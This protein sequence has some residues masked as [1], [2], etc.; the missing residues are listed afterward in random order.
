MENK[1]IF[2]EYFKK[3]NIQIKNIPFNLSPISKSTHEQ[4]K[5][6]SSVDFKDFTFPTDYIQFCIEIGAGKLGRCRI[7]APTSNMGPTDLRFH[8]FRLLSKFQEQKTKV[9]Q[10]PLHELIIFANDIE[11]DLWFGWRR[12]NQN[13]IYVIDKRKDAPP[14]KKIADNFIEFLETVCLGNRMEKMKIK[15]YFEP[16]KEPK[17]GEEN[18]ISDDDDSDDENSEKSNEPNDVENFPPKTFTPFPKQ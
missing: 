4:F 11:E 9:H 17:E 2:S 8:T 5:I 3:W 16:P 7:F 14:P 13:V 10:F 1:Q 6:I 18:V 12:E 15:K